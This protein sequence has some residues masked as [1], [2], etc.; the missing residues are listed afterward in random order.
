[1]TNDI[2]PDLEQVDGISNVN[3]GGSLTPAIEVAG[4]PASALLR[5]ALRS[6]TSSARSRQNNNREPGGIAYLPNRE[7]TIDVRGDV[8][9]VATV[10]NLPIA[11]ASQFTT[12]FGNASYSVPAIPG[13]PGAP[14]S[15]SSSQSG[16][17]AGTVSLPSAAPQTRRARCRLRPLRLAASPQPSFS[18]APTPSP[19]VSVAAAATAI[20]TPTPLPAS[21]SQNGSAD[22]SHCKRPRRRLPSPRRRV[23]ATTPTNG[24][25]AGL[26]VV[27][28]ESMERVAA[29]DA[30]LRRR[31]G[32]RLVRAA[33]PVQL[34]RKRARPF[35]WACRRRPMRVKLRA[36]Q[37][38]LKALPA[39]ERTY[40]GHRLSNPQQSSGVYQA[41]NLG[42]LSHADRSDSDHRRRDALLFALVAQ[43]DRRADRDSRL[44]LRDA[45]H[46]EARELHDRYR[47]AIGDDAHHRHF[48]RRLD[49]RARKHRT[50]S[51]KRRRRRRRPRSK[52]ERRSGPRRSSLRWST[53]SSFLPI[54]FL[55]GTVGKFLSE[56][57][58]V[59]V[60]ATLT[61]LAVSFTITPSL[62]G[63]WS[64]LS[65]WKAPKPIERFAQRLR[66]AAAMVRAAR[67]SV[68][69]CAAAAHL[70]RFGG[71]RGRF[72]LARAAGRRRIRVHAAGR[73][74]RG[75][76]AAYLS[77]RHAAR[78]RERG[79]HAQS[80]T[81]L[82]TL[83][84]VDSLTALAGGT[85]SNF[86]GMLAQGSVGQIHVFLKDEPPALDRLRSAFLRAH[87][88]PGRADGTRRRDSGH[89]RRRRKRAAYRL[90]RN[91]D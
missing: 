50:P 55:P 58:L 44:A 21:Q 90:S 75:L 73:S 35:R 53:S 56:F 86:G 10:A 61:S 24:G 40:P 57:A 9:N 31:V 19:Y 16:G 34:R 84:D 26:I 42:R 7:T 8:T 13:A 30:H 63:N 1:M 48:G 79:D 33:T 37:N 43:R 70:C 60:A 72:D 6:T 62:A 89:R 5:R 12:S 76:R 82:R 77:D 51:R 25:Y 67:A 38:V 14:T 45:D 68:G 4:R 64:L 88:E 54:A 66:A 3:V 27:D 28:V 78:D 39:I 85:Q 18:P 15:A 87:R 2:V 74:R 46:D 69:A 32:Y 47:L 65:R 71:G 83:S 29:T 36:A 17:G 49:R 23:S 52:D 59:V 41:A 11:A 22:A 20:A 80:T 91:L 81:L